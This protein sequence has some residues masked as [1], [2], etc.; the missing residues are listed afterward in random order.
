MKGTVIFAIR[1]QT[2]NSL[3][4]VVRFRI[5]PYGGKK[6][7]TNT[8]NLFQKVELAKKHLFDSIERIEVSK[9]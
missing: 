1:N 4:Y 5:A 9:T 2:V 8:L 7:K 6:W 3:L